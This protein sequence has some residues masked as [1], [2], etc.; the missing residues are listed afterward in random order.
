[1]GSKFTI[2]F[3]YLDFLF[4]GEVS[5]Q[6]ID[7]V[8]VYNVFYALA[9]NPESIDEVEIYQGSGPGHGVYWRQRL[10]TREAILTDP[11]LVIIIGQAIKIQEDIE[12][13]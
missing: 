12:S 1:M 3:T 7:R 6:L 2:L 13:R 9:A 11:E 5:K 8:P 10:I 4:L